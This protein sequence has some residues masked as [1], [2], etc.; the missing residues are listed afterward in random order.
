MATIYAG[1]GDT[2]GT[3][4]NDSI[5]GSHL[6]DYIDGGRGNDW[7]QGN[8]GNDRVYGWTGNDTIWGGSGDDII[9]G[10]GGRD[11]L[12]GHGGDD[13][14][15]FEKKP[16]RSNV[17]KIMDFNVKDDMFALDTGVFKGVK[18]GGTEMKSGAFWVGAQAH[19]SDDR[20]IYNKDTGAVYYV[21][22]GTGSRSAIQFATISENLKLTYRD[23]YMFS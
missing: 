8:R 1:L 21:P 23:F 13:L 10:D 15:E 22:D 3:S 5:Y 20:I 6:R 4:K 9:G 18:A 17:D 2:Y 14:F 12:T 7:I 16:S 19:D 11:V